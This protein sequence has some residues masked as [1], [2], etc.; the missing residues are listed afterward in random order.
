VVC[1]C[2]LLI[3]ATWKW[4]MLCRKRFVELLDFF[5][6]FVESFVFPSCPFGPSRLCPQTQIGSQSCSSM[7]QEVL[8]LNGF[9]L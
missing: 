1:G 8:S 4:A 9:S 6:L 7:D 5:V 2:L 3:L